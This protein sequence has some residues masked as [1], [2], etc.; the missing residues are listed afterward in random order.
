LEQIDMVTALVVDDVQTD[1]SVLTD[2]LESAGWRVFSSDSGEA[3]LDQLPKVLPDIILLDVVLPGKS[4][5]EICRSI[6]TQVHTQKI[7]VVICS[8]KSTDMDR[9]W[10]MKQ[11]ADLYL[12]KPF[13]GEGLIEMLQKLLAKR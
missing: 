7:P 13:V 9:F 11:G 6:K 1:R 5:Y 12:T 2:Y 10:G 4:G 3:A 8:S